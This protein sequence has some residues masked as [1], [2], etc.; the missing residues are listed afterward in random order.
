MDEDEEMWFNDDEEDYENSN[1]AKVK[2]CYVALKA[3]P[4]QNGPAEKK[5]TN[6]DAEKKKSGAS[7]I[8]ETTNTKAAVKMVNIDFLL[9]VCCRKNVKF[10]SL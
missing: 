3:C 10:W 7:N 9:T 4:S 5:A 8:S 2:D 6:E 1:D